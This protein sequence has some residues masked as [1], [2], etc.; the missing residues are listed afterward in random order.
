MIAVL[1]V[2]KHNVKT[3]VHNVW[4]NLKTGWRQMARALSAP[5]AAI[6]RHYKKEPTKNEKKRI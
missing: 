4:A 1:L 6:G 3:Q 2:V 5:V